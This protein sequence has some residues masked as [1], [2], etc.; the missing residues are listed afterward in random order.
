MINDSIRT[1]QGRIVSACARCKRDPAT[2]RLIAVTKGRSITEI[3]DIIASGY[4]HIGENRVQEASLKYS[5]ILN[6]PDAQRI[7]WHMLGHLQTNKAREAV[8]M[9]CCIHSVDS[10]RLAKEID[11]HACSLGKT[12]DILL[13]VKTSSD[14]SKFGFAPDEV[15]PLLKQITTLLHV[16]VIGL[17]TIAALGARGEDARP[18]FRQLREL[19]DQLNAILPAQYVIR[20]LSMGMSDDFEVAIE[21]GATFV[22]IGRAIFE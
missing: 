16:R 6:T 22:R 5:A 17:M 11:K 7:Q 18:Y 21:E 8:R 14:E 1:I 10:F 4:L 12:Q 19:R 3:Q 2:V 20:E 15:A 13:E 9:F